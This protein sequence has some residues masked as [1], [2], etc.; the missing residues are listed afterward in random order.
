MRIAS[1][2]EG[3]VVIVQDDLPTARRIELA[4][5]QAGATVFTTVDA[6]QTL[7]LMWRMEPFAVVMNPSDD[8]AG[9]T[10]V[11]AIARDNK[12]PVVQYADGGQGHGEGN[13]ISR[14]APVQ[15]IVDILLETRASD[16]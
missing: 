10:F 2:L 9:A 14:G 1:P 13:R 8:L 12:V 15:D 3:K 5:G 6:R 4:L 16:P 7:D 11:W